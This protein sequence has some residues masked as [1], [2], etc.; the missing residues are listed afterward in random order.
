MGALGGRQWCPG[1]AS[2]AGGACTTQGALWAH[3][4]ANS[5]A[6][7]C[8]P[9]CTNAVRRSPGCELHFCRSTCCSSSN[10][11]TGIPDATT[12]TGTALSMARATLSEFGTCNG[13]FTPTEQEL[14]KWGM[15]LPYCWDTLTACAVA[16]AAAVTVA[17]TGSICI[18]AKH[19][20]WQAYSCTVK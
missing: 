14:A 5:A 9:V 11:S 8:I 1:T 19:H 6:K 10:P 17:A 18:F 13:W 16:A 12:V 15:R 20:T 3:V 7:G 4:T 2:S